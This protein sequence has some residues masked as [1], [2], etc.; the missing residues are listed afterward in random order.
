VPEAQIDWDRPVKGLEAPDDRTLVIHL[1]DPYPQ[2]RYN[3]AHLPT[4]PMSRDVVRY[5]GEKVKHHPVGTGP[6]VLQEHLPEQRV[7]FVANPIYRGKSDIDGDAQ[8]PP[9]QH[10]PFIKRVQMD[11][12][13][14]DLPAWALFQQGMLDVAGIP[15]D[16]FAQAIDNTRNLNPEMQARGIRLYKTPSPDV[17]FYGFNMLDPVVGKNKPLRQAMSMAFDR[18][19][20]IDLFAN[21]R[22][23]PANGPIPP[24]FPTYD[25]KLVNPY[26]QFN[27]PAAREKMQEAIRING[28]PI[29]QITFLMPGT[30]TT[31]RQMGEYMTRQMDQIGVSI[32]VDYVTW[33]RFQEMVDNRQAQFYALGWVADYPDE[34]TF[35][36]LF[37]SKN[38][39]PGPNSANY[40]N[41]E[42]DKLYER[43]MVMEPGPQRDA[44]YRQMQAIVNDDTPWLMTYY[45]TTY[46][47][48]YD[49]VG[50]FGENEYAHGNRKFLRLDS[51]KRVDWLKHH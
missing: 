33:A 48:L 46:R 50:N 32:R 16:T 4:A 27:L 6:Y 44:L 3:M 17:W 1:T 14:E 40:S 43:A 47:L 49:W 15:K 39:A 18:R 23:E 45:S 20:F 11:Y 28:G 8:L 34:Q 36:Q 41:P 7:V 24:G 19:R 9:D 31:F 25:P 42:Y 30:D 51:Q 29:P 37:W 12:F 10:M 38:A 35:L 26:T 2:L 5:W 22:G 21:G 13:D